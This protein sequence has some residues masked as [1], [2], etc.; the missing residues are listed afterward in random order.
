MFGLFADGCLDER[1]EQRMW[2]QYRTAVFRMELSAD[3]PLQCR[4]LND[5]HQIRF[6]VD[7]HAFHTGSF[8]LSLIVIVELIAMAVTFLNMFFTISKVCFRSFLKHTFV[9]AQTHR[10]SHIGDRFLFLHDVDHVVRSSFHPFR[11]SRHRHIPIR[12]G[13]IR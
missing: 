3:K 4:D 2:F 7:T 8:V 9:S 1:Q 10:T 12:C 5:F 11:V 6:G 13:Q